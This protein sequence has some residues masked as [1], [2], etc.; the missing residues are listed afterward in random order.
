MNKFRKCLATSAIALALTFGCGSLVQVRA[1]DGSG[2]PQ[3]QTDSRS[4]GPSAPTMTQ[5]EYEYLVW[6]IVMWLLGWL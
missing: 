5:A 2:G 3:G 1:D 6:L 4:G